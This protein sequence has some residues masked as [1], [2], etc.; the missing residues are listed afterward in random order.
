[1]P[2]E[3]VE[4]PGAAVVGNEMYPRLENRLPASVRLDHVGDRLDD[5]RAADAKALNVRPGQKPQPDPLRAHPLIIFGRARGAMSR[6]GGANGPF[7]MMFLVFSNG[8]LVP[9]ISRARSLARGGT[10]GRRG[11]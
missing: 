6:E 8:P 11:S 10:S 9:L 4:M 2:P 1:M 5:L 7:G 3:H